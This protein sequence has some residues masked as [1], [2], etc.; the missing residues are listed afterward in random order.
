METP[1]PLGMGFEAEGV[2]CV[3]QLLLLSSSDSEAH[4]LSLSLS[5]L[6]GPT[7]AASSSQQASTTSSSTSNWTRRSSSSTSAPPSSTVRFGSHAR[8]LLP[9]L[10]RA[11]P[12]PLAGK[13]KA[14]DEHVARLEKKHKMVRPRPFA[15]RST[16]RHC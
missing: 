11:R 7:R 14:L 10:T 1:V 3:P 9:L 13:L 12:A 2:V 15:S 4:P 8:R 6:A 5:P 16:C